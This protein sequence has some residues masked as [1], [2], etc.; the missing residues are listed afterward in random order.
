LQGA[1]SKLY[2]KVKPLFLTRGDW[3]RKFSRKDSFVQ[4][5]SAQPKVF[6]VGS[7]SALHS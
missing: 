4:R 2:R 3:Q 5:I 1:E 7:E 6:I